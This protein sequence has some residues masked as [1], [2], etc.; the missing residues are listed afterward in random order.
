MIE[1][2]LPAEVISA[3]IV[4]DD[5]TA[6]LLPE[7][8]AM[9]ARS[10]EK[11]RREVTNARTCARRALGRL[12]LPATPILRGAKGEPLWP[13]GV[14]GSIT[15]TAGYYAAA[16]ADAG[17]VRS[18][19]IDAEVHDQLPDGVLRHI[20]VAE[21]LAWLKEIG[22]HQAIWWERLLFSAKESVYKAWFP[23]ARRWL[24][25]EDALITFDPDAGTFAVRLLVDGTVES[26]PPLSE[27]SGRFLAEDGYVLTAITLPHH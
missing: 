9:V 13:A 6:A 24:G 26:G 17:R 4:G 16:V 19:G 8:Q 7:E 2:L 23:L 12:G 14:V 10:V 22:R 11:R 15:H 21:E 1:R 5:P 3:E 25:F 20:A 18:V 27:L